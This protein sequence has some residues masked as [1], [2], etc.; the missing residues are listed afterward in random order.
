M[1]VR[2]LRQDGKYDLFVSHAKKLPETEDRAVWIADVAEGHGL[3]PFF[4]RSDL[5]EITEPALKQAL[6]LSDVSTQRLE[7]CLSCSCGVM[8]I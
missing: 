3:L 2:E 8:L 7:P 4:D 5:V 1:R 6:L